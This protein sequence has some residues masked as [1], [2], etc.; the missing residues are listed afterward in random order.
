MWSGSDTQEPEMVRVEVLFVRH[1]HGCH[2]A[3]KYHTATIKYVVSIG[4]MM[5]C[6]YPDPPL[7][8]CGI[9]NSR[10]NGLELNDA[11]N[12]RWNWKPQF[13]GSSSMIRAIET[14]SSMFPNYEVFPLPFISENGNM[15]CNKPKPLTEQQAQLSNI[16]I[17][18]KHV[19]KNIVLKD[20]R[21]KIEEAS[22]STGGHKTKWSKDDAREAAMYK[23]F[24]AFLGERIVP[25]LLNGNSTVKVVI[26]SHSAF[27]RTR[28]KKY[29]NCETYFVNNAAMLT[30]Y[31]YNVS[32]KQVFEHTSSKGRHCTSPLDHPPSKLWGKE[33]KH[34]CPA[35]YARCF[36]NP[37]A[38]GKKDGVAGDQSP[39]I[40]ANKPGQECCV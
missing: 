6:L 23:E 16:S 10:A 24:R 26:V 1:G 40:R 18:W 3:L 28:L 22:F 38:M 21:L 2:N 35:D 15:P 4:S 14:A 9:A 5:H 34:A 30:V 17:N 7:T 32:S 12:F 8:D 37:G 25:G 11:L 31:D 33:K 39:W 29:F 20:Y 36:V 13:V 19:S 27:M